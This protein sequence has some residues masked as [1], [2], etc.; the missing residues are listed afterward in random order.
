M[1]PHPLEAHAR[2]TRFSRRVL[3]YLSRLLQNLLRTL[4]VQ[5]TIVHDH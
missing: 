2:G 1:P 3:L 4:T 5:V